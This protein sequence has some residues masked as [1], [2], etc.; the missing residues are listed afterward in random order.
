MGDF[1]CQKCGSTDFVVEN[2]MYVCTYCGSRYP[3]PDSEKGNANTG[4]Y[5][6]RPDQGGQANPA[7]GTN[8]YRQADTQRVYVNAG[9]AAGPTTTYVVIKSPKGWLTTLLLCI[10]LGFFGVHRFYVGKVGTGI[11][12]LLTLGCFG[13]G[14]LV[15]LIMI[16]I[17]KFTDKQGRVI[18][19][20]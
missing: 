12:W 4:G 15:D 19:N 5:V 6:Y 1:K 3:I 7:G 13:I 17:G 8:Q 2:G 14:W 20:K 16:I 10:F 11:I 18:T 9:Q